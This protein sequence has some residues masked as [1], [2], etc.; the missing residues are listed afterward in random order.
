MPR[1]RTTVVCQN[2]SASFFIHPHKLREGK[3]KFCSKPCANEGTRKPRSP[4]E[5]RFWA[6]VEKSDSCWE[7]KGTINENGYGM[8]TIERKPQRAHRISYTLKRGPIPNG[9][10]VLHHCDNRCCVNPDHLF[11][12]TYLDNSRDMDAKGRRR[13]NVRPG[14]GSPTHILTEEQV[15]EIRK[16]K[17]QGISTKQISASF[18]IA[19]STVFQIVNRQTW[20]HI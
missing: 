16:Q 20:K 7:W 11:L 6:K 1:D 19:K 3:G 5:D 18:G 12:G 13:S 10:C 9:M 8:I 17:E 15:L 14:E 4:L 2:C